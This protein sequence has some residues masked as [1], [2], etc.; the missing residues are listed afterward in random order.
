VVVLFV[1]ALYF[2]NVGGIPTKDIGPV[3]EWWVAGFDGGEKALVGFSTG[4]GEYYLMEPSES[5]APFMKTVYEKTFISKT[6]IEFLLEDDRATYEDL[7]NRL[8]VWEP[9][10]TE[11]WPLLLV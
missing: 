2:L 8:Q 1:D 11:V 9:S 7:L 10:F 6:V 3:N 5:Y 4:F